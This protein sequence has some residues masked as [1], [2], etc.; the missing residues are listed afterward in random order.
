MKNILFICKSG[1]DRS[2]CAVELFEKSEKY[3]AKSCG[4]LSP[5]TENPISDF[6]VYKWA[7]EIIILDEDC[8]EEFKK[9]YPKRAK[10]TDE[11]FCIPIP[12]LNRNDPELEEELRGEVGGVSAWCVRKC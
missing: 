5:L 8:F 3:N 11:I 1:L 6:L 12:E 7:Q 10:F 4:I 2:P 9:R